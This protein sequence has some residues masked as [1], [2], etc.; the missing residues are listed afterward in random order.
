MIVRKFEE[1][2]KFNQWWLW[3]LLFVCS[4]PAFYALFR[5][6]HKEQTLATILVLLALVITPILLFVV[7]K[8]DTTITKESINLRFRPFVSRSYKWVDVE[9][10]EVINYG[11]VG[12][13]GIR[14]GTKY[15]T[16][17]NVRGKM[18]LHVVLKSGKT[19]VVGTQKE[20]ELANFLNNLNA[21]N[22]EQKSLGI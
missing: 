10:V 22:L 14:M 12:G 9:S 21:Y 13:W 11:F 20:K 2:Q 17:Y 5:L 19:F 18:G 6:D 15:G 4:A 16:V 1:T 8:M 7:I 3:L